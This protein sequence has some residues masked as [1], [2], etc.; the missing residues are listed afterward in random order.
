MLKRGMK[1]AARLPGPLV[2]AGAGLLVAGG[3]PGGAAA[4]V[5]PQSLS[6]PKA[7]LNAVLVGGRMSAGLLVQVDAAGN[8]Y[9]FVLRP[10]RRGIGWWRVA[11]GVPVSPLDSATYRPGFWA[12]V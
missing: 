5:D 2:R 4:A 6:Q 10:E 9:A 12:S 7:H 3:L 1:G 11:G 8:G